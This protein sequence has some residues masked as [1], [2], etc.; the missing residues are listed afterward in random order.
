[1]A[2][3]EKLRTDIEIEIPYV[4]MEGKQGLKKV[5]IMFISQGIYNLYVSLIND[6]MEVLRIKDTLDQIIQRMGQTA[7]RVQ[8]VKDNEGKLT[9]IKTSILEAR[10]KMKE[11]Q[12]EYDRAIARMNDISDHLDERKQSLIQKILKKNGIEDTDLWSTEWW[13][14][15]TE[16]A[17]DM[18]FIT[19]ACEKDSELLMGKKKLQT[20]MKSSI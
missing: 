9:T 18:R 7:N 14:E 15:C 17:E 1:M 12:E 13:K 11:A 10:K 20:P 6:T 16:V 4:S 2:K 5:R 8:V 19:K 3:E